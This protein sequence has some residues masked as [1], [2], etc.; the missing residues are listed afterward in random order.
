MKNRRTQRVIATLAVCALATAA[1]ACGSSNTNSSANSPTGG[2]GA[3][4]IGYLGSLSGFCSAFSQDEVA[5]ARAAVERLNAQG[6]VLGHPLDLVVRDDQATP[7]V[8]VSQA[9][10]LVLTQ[11]IRFLA[12]TCSSAVSLAVRKSV[13]DPSKVFYVAPSGDPSVFAGTG[14]GGSYVFGTLPVTPVEGATVGAF[15]KGL[16]GVKTVSF[17]GEDYSYSR[18]VFAAFQQAEKGG[19][20]QI[21]S[22]D[23]ATVGDYTPYINKILSKKPDFV[24][25]D[26]ITG[27]AAT[28]VKQAGPLGLFNQLGPGGMIGFYDLSTLIAMGKNAPV[29]QYGYDYYP[30]PYLYPGKEM[31]EVASA[32]KTETGKTATGAFGDGYNQISMIAQAIEKAGAVDPGKAA[33][34]LSGA[35]VKFIQGPVTIRPCDHLPVVPLAIGKVASP[36]KQLPFPHLA[37]PKI[38][39]TKPYYPAC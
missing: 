19:S 26:L 20:Q 25:N 39:D 9:R 24:Y 5:G 11:G 22:A 21:I 12:G 14:S 10:D 16:P 36:T 34:A 38:I 4:K 17:I 6:G 3:I 2:K 33:K 15:I 37:N 35:T 32:Y 28:F 29:G 8:G 1:T 23:F 27:D 13:A 30:E 7:N 18:G 31:N